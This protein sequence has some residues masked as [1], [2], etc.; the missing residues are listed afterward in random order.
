MDAGV[1]HP[2]QDLVATNDAVAP[3]LGEHPDREEGLRED[4]APRLLPVLNWWDGIGVSVGVVVSDP[5]ARSFS[6]R[7]A[8]LARQSG[9]QNDD[10]L[11]QG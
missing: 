1:V 4:G 5:F 8:D 2:R 3:L 10:I 6:G 9:A 7:V 11:W